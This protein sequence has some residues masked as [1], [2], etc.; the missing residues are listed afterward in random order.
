[1]HLSI[2]ELVIN[3]CWFL[4][5]IG[6]AIFFDIRQRSIV[7]KFAKLERVCSPIAKFIIDSSKLGVRDIRLD[8]LAPTEKNSWN[9]PRN[10]RRQVVVK[11]Q[12]E[13]GDEDEGVDWGDDEKPQSKKKK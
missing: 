13:Q 10:P 3:I 11:S 4:L 7:R 6:M 9:R 12:D 8:R 2:L 5:F 1:M